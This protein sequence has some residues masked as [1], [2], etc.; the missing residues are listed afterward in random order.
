MF[1]LANLKAGKEGGRKHKDTK[2]QRSKGLHGFLWLLE[3]SAVR[4]LVQHLNFEIIVVAQLRYRNPEIN[5]G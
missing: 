4:N 1:F 2:S 3:V 5:S